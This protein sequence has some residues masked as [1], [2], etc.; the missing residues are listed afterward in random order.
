[1]QATIQYIKSELATTYPETEIQGFIRLIFE[2]LLNLSYTEMLL[3]KEKKI[4]D[5]VFMEIKNIVAR[6]KTHEPIQYILGETEFYELKLKVNPA[7]LI[8]RPETEELVQWILKSDI[9]PGAEII[10]IGTGSGCIALALRNEWP[11]SVVTAVDISEKALKTARGNAVL[12]KLN[13][14]F[15]KADILNWRNYDWPKYSVIVSNP[16][17]V[18][19]CEKRQMENN[20]LKYEPDEALFV[21]DDNPLLFYITIAE[22]AKFNL[23]HK[24]Y[25]FFEIN[26]YLGSEMEELL[27]GLGFRN[28]ELRKDMNGR[29]RMLKCQ[30]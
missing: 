6:L 2:L 1:M 27:N 24:G 28:I 23:S 18:R 9:E 15:L 19:E 10:D 11:E 16:P 20:V 25:L 13:V 5:G 22:F 14:K 26:E 12:N 4:D 8:P 3:Q 7:V 21:E 29:D 17:Y 30:K